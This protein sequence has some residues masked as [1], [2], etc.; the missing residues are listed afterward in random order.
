ML[1]CAS[2]GQATR[3]IK[4]IT[5]QF[6]LKSR[7]EGSLH[8]ATTD[9]ALAHHLHTLSSSA[10]DTHTDLDAGEAGGRGGGRGGVRGGGEGVRYI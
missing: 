1:F 4:E 5:K 3:R 10:D 2:R 6:V 8:D 7:G 9:A